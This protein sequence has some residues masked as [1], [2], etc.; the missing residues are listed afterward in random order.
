MLA[1]SLP[2]T[3]PTSIPSELEQEMVDVEFDVAT[4]ITLADALRQGLPL[5]GEQ[6]Y[7]WGDGKLTGCALTTAAR[8]MYDNGYA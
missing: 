4:G 8:W 5:V 2:T 3:G 6:A 7:G 1:P